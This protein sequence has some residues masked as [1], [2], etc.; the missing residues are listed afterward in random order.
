MDRINKSLSTAFTHFDNNLLTLNFDSSFSSVWNEFSFLG[1]FFYGLV[2]V[3]AILHHTD[4]C[5]IGTN[6]NRHVEVA[7]C[8]IFFSENH[9]NS[10]ETSRSTSQVNSN[11]RRIECSHHLFFS[12]YL[13]CCSLLPKKKL[14]QTSLKRVFHTFMRF[15]VALSIISR[16]LLL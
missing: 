16:C 10:P 14:K 11:W 1:L 2:I 8:V 3:F 15:I 9:I 12:R 6:R 13:S 5:V 4:G 7:I